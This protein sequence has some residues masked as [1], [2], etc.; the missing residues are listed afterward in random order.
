MEI[1]LGAATVAVSRAGASFLAECAAMRV[2]AV[3]VPYPAA[4]D[5]HQ[6]HN[7]RAFEQTHAAYLLPQSKL[8]ADALALQLK[9][10]IEGAD[11]RESIQAALAQWHAPDAAA[12]IAEGMLHW[13]RESHTFAAKGLAGR[14]SA[15]AR[16]AQDRD[17][18]VSLIPLQRS[19]P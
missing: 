2:P 10:L 12:K 5:D 4:V 19:N 17:D 1:A 15:P 13:G 16:S 6:Y 7:A 18:I 8:S 9:R 11:E 3:L 14:H